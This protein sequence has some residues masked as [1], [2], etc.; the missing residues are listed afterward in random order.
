MTDDQIAQL[1]DSVE[2]RVIR[3]ERGLPIA[4]TRTTLYNPM[5]YLKAGWPPALIGSWLNL[6]VE[7]MADALEYIAAHQAAVEAEYQTVLQHSQANRDY[8][9]ARNR[10]RRARIA[11]LPPKPE[12]AALQAKLQARKA[13]LGLK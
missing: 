13:E 5:D 1:P 12:Q 4:G 9:E 10:N 2:G 11:A 8:W 7:Q 3:T 6:S